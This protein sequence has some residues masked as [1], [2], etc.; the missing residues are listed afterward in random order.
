MHVVFP[1]FATVLPVHYWECPARGC[2]NTTNHSSSG[3][4]KVHVPNTR[5]HGLE[6]FVGLD[7]GGDEV[8]VR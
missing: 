8:V 3:L 1:L 5:H 2:L 7:E 4:N 6:D